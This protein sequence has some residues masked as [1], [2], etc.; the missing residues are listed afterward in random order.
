MKE[1]VEEKPFVKP[2]KPAS[3]LASLVKE[4]QTTNQLIALLIEVLV[5]SK[6]EKTLYAIASEAKKLIKVSDYG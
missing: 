1:L 5:Y 6:D 4:L 3:E 2:S